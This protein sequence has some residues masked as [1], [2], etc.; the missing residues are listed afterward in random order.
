ISW[1]EA[2]LGNVWV[3]LDPGGGYF[4]W[5]PN[6]Y[7][8]LYRD[9]LPLI[10]HTAGL[11]LEYDF[12]VHRIRKEPAAVEPTPP[13]PL[14]GG[15]RA[16]TPLVRALSSYVERPV[17]SVV[18]ISDEAVD[19]S[20]SESMFREAREAEINLVLLHAPFESRYF[21]EQYLQRL[22]SNN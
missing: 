12:L 11:D 16:G 2:Y 5:V 4:G 8:A 6:Q 21:R 22:V 10:V 13:A 20:V 3:P 19:E 17:A 18:M 1:V 7:L 9:D 15:A 14:R